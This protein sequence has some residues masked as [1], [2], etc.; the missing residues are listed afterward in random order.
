MTSRSAGVGWATA[1][2]EAGHAVACQ[3]LGIRVRKASIIPE[4]DTLGRVGYRD[5]WRGINLECDN[6]A[7]GDR[8]AKDMIIVALAGPEAQRKHSRRSWRS[9]HGSY[10]HAKVADLALRMNGSNESTDAYVR[11]LEIATRD[12][13]AI[14]W[15][16][17]EKVARA[18]FERN[19]LTA[20]EIEAEL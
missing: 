6:S 20:A 18:L 1:F 12:L 3:R 13:V 10:D 15:P 5:P 17:I 2:H 14:W 7:R 8:R 11:W 9:W 19:E 16:E 4:K